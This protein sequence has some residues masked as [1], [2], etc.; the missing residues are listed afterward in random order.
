VA[1][2]YMYLP[3]EGAEAWRPVEAEPVGDA[4]RIVSECPDGE[5]L[6][7]QPEDVVRCET[8]M[9]GQS[10]RR[11]W[12]RTLWRSRGSGIAI[13]AAKKYLDRHLRDGTYLAAHDARRGQEAI[14]D[15]LIS[16]ETRVPQSH[17][18]RAIKKVG[19][20]QCRSRLGGALNYYSR[21]AA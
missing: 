13:R 5:Q 14:V 3:D 11:S 10:G 21:D 9:L 1:T 8:R 7:F 16:P 4:F 20:I 19:A 15:V 12:D 18:L 2:I 6:E 17:P